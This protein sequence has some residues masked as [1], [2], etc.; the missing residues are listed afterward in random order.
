MFTGRF[1]RDGSTLYLSRVTGVRYIIPACSMKFGFKVF[2][3][4]REA[5]LRH[6]HAT[7]TDVLEYIDLSDQM[8]AKSQRQYKRAL[9]HR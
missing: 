2:V 3:E 8:I 9:G 1:L 7:R 5:R 6:M 4:G